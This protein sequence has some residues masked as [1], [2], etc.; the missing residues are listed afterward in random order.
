[1]GRRG[2]FPFS[3]FYVLTGERVA[4]TRSANTW[5][6]D[7]QYSAAAD[8]LDVKNLVVTLVVVSATAA[9]GRIVLSDITTSAVK[10][11]L[12]VATSGAT[13]VF[14]FSDSPI[15]F[16]NGIRVTTLSNAVAT[17]IGKPTGG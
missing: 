8:D 1:V 15:I 17:V 7:T 2:V 9:T 5:Y 13:Q 12:L 6:V 10:L 14:D 16:S 11:D 4:N 3:L